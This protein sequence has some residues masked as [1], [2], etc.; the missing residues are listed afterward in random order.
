MVNQF[1][2]SSRGCIIYRAY[3]RAYVV[4]FHRYEKL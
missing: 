3:M 1:T 2:I 4:V